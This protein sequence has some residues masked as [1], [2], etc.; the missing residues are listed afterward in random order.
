MQAWASNGPSRK[1]RRGEGGPRRGPNKR[2]RENEPMELSP[3]SN[4][5]EFKLSTY[6]GFEFEFKV[7]LEC[8]GLGKTRGRS[9]S[10][11]V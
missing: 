4:F 6:E 11:L 9:R 3:F 7:N 2:G 8:G 10:I 1:R 5:L